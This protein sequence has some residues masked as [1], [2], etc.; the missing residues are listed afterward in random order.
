MM[1]NWI[2]KST[3]SL[4][5]INEY[6][7]K[8]KQGDF[9]LEIA[10]PD[11]PTKEEKILFNISEVAKTVRKL[12]SNLENDV[13]TLYSA[14]ENLDNIANSSAGI[15][16]EVAKTVEGLAINATNQVSDLN[17]CNENVN[18]ATD[19][20][21]KINTRIQDINKIANNFVNIAVQSR[22]DADNSLEKINNIQSSSL[23]V[24]EQ[25]TELG[26][27]SKEIGQI[28]DLITTIARQTNMLALNAAI[29]AARAGEQGRGFAV[30][31]EEVK[32]L[33]EQTAS[34]AEKIKGMA[35]TIQAKAEKA[36]SSTELSLE[37][38]EQGASSF[39]LIKSNFDNVYEQAN[40]INDE[41]K[42]I[43]E[44][45]ELLV[46]KNDEVLQAIGSISNATELNAASAEEISASTQEHSAGIQELKNH[47]NRILIM[48]RNLTVSSSIF[49]LDKKPEIFYW[50][51]KFF[52][53]IPE[54]DY[55][56]YKI[57]NYVNELYREY[58][59]SRN[60]ERLN[61]LLLELAEFAAGHFATEE[62]LMQANNY[63]N[64]NAHLQEHKKLLGD[65]GDFIARLKDN[66]AEI[67]DKILEFL[68]NWLKRHIL[69][70]DM[71]YAPYLKK[72]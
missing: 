65:V 67:D 46:K 30:V 57:V 47:A 18:D 21:H 27:T 23:Q 15:A 26:K 40:T 68:N 19:T 70:V 71:Q 20:S 69:E 9:S 66:R 10:P 60:K 5:E 14:G 17:I 7:E 8:M 22:R 13:K 32:K 45:I 41:T 25:I 24:S 42:G 2:K 35:H 52:T 34:A 44:T 1:K 56:H 39:G 48:A 55:Q 50:S 63:P 29:E 16:T 58:T 62:K 59:G 3:V 51:G 72:C 33:A 36:V 11:N 53:G 49:K 43:S 37:N 64:F 4:E 6:L 31:A 38:V 54:I 12:V 61:A 28:V